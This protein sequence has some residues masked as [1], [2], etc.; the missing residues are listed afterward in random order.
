MLQLGQVPVGGGAPGLR[1]RRRRQ[2]RGRLLDQILQATRLQRLLEAV[3]QPRGAVERGRDRIS[4]GGLTFSGPR[5][6]APSYAVSLTITS[7][8]RSIMSTRSSAIANAVQNASTSQSVARRMRDSGST[9]EIRELAKAVH[10]LAH[11][12]Q[13]LGQAIKNDD[14]PKPF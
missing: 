12:V 2:M 7:R 4:R 3:Q 9:P 5:G 11:A 13:E 8:R 10:F 6:P 1:I 14:A